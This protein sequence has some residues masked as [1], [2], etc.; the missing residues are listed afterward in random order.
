MKP[1]KCS[2]P[3]CDKPH[4]GRGLCQGHCFQQRR[5]QELRPLRPSS[6]GLT[7]EQ[8]FWA[9]VKKTPGCWEWTAATTSHGYGQIKVNGRM[10]PAHRVSWELTNG[11]IPAGMHID[12]RCANRKCV[13]PEHLRV[14]TRSQNMQHLTGP[15]KDNTSGIRGVTWDKRKNA[16]VAQ[17]KLNGRLYHG[18]L[19]STLEAAD[20]AARALRAKLFTHDDHEA[21]GR[22]MP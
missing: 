22:G 17:A 12:H 4:Y 2:F 6:R 11:T 16:W 13:N 18:G 14:T 10:R 7:L 9:K 1:T 15:R 5:G 20:K 21:W 19:H 3:G 8:R